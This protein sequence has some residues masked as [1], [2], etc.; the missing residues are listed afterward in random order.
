MD[1]RVMQFRVGV[2]V[3]STFLIAGILAV[4]FGKIPGFGKPTYELKVRF[5][6]ADGISRNSSLKVSGVKIGQVSKNPE[7][8]PDKSVIITLQ[9][10]DDYQVTHD[11]G[12]KIATTL[13]GDS[14]LQVTDIGG[15]NKAPYNP[16][17][18]LEGISAG[19]PQ[20]IMKD[21]SGSV[22][23]TVE[24]LGKTSDEIRKMVVTINSRLEENKD[25]F[26]SIVDATEKTLLG[27]N[28]T[29]QSVQ[30]ILGDDKL[31]EDL[32]KSIEEI[33]QVLASMKNTVNDVQGAVQSAS[34]NIQNLEGL[35]KPLG[36]RGGAMAANLD[37]VLGRLNN[38]LGNIELLSKK[39][40]SN[41]GTAGSLLSNNDLYIQLND[42]AANINELTRQLRPIV[43]DA[44][45]LTDKL[46][47]NPGIILRDA[48][49]PGA[50]TKF[51]TTSQSDY[52][53]QREREV[54]YEDEAHYSIPH[55]AQYGS[56][57]QQPMQQQSIQQQNPPPSQY[58]QQPNRQQFR[59]PNT[60][61]QPA[62]NYPVQ[63]AQF[64]QP[65][66]QNP[67]ANQ[68]GSYNPMASGQ[69]SPSR[70]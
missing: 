63:P 7:I 44:R 65:V 22:G 4:L 68:N 66:N 16:G 62:Q 19:N 51:L 24:S 15:I 57:Q 43:A 1:D 18:T 69:W 11:Q 36:D 38:T 40:N 28:K 5:R 64:N 26:A 33:P 8:Q 27:L 9:V 60:Q 13:L 52:S 49:F 58:A 48:A 39:L 23:S 35:T 53:M 25:K 42:S 6:T 37:S 59:R 70:N 55:H 21:L 56:A 34:R 3:L 61:A 29:L 54:T 46:A 45:V 50:G 12:I 2:M 32:R 67:P 20:D 41:E 17:D 47:R 14:D 31:K 10:N 30:G